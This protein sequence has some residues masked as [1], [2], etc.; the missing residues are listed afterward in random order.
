[1]NFRIAATI[2]T[3][4]AC[5]LALTVMLNYVKFERTFS[6][7]LESRFAFVVLDLRTVIQTGLD[8]GLELSAMSNIQT[9]LERAAERDDQILSIAVYDEQNNLAFKHSELGSSEQTVPPDWLAA[10]QGNEALDSYVGDPDVGIVG[11]ALINNFGYR[12]G[13]I[14]LRYDDSFY[15]LALQ[16]TLLELIHTAV[17]I[18]GITA[19]VAIIWVWLLFH[20]INRSL[21]RMQAAI[22]ELLNNPGTGDFQ[23]A[24]NSELEMCYVD[25]E[26][27]SLEALNQLAAAQKVLVLEQRLGRG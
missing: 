5:A 12:V 23:P 15:T 19:L 16:H 7:L 2:T 13:S 18:L 24:H 27:K 9:V 3:A 10:S 26:K 17:A 6:R 14:V 21:L 1:M 20:G 4:V 25:T 11:M 8:L 22:S